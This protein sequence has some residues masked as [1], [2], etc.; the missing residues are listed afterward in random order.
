MQCLFSIQI[1][2]PLKNVT[3]R[4]LNTATMSTSLDLSSRMPA[5][6][7]LRDIVTYTA[8]PL[9]RILYAQ[10]QQLLVQRMARYP[11]LLTDSRFSSG[12]VAAIL[13]DGVELP[14]SEA[15]IRRLLEFYSIDNEF[16]PALRGVYRKWVKTVYPNWLSLLL[17]SRLP[18]QMPGVSVQ[19]I[20]A[21]EQQGFFVSPR[22]A[23]DGWFRLS[24]AG[25]LAQAGVSLPHVFA[26]QRDTDLLV[27][28]A[29]NPISLL[30]HSLRPPSRSDIQNFVDRCTP[31]QRAEL[32]LLA[33]Q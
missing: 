1:L 26:S 33:R 14:D 31:S 7:R 6:E 17:T 16:T 27:Y 22:D 21:M 29:T 23:S 11:H 32:A 28:H 20:N 25:Q 10:H 8:D 12:I 9:R 3:S 5:E 2:P 24:A 4:D 30:I 15:G 19:V 13:S 18:H